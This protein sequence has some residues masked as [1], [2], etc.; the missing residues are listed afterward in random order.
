MAW[1]NPVKNDLHLWLSVTHKDMIA[2]SVYD[3]KGRL[4]QEQRFQ[5]DK[6]NQTK[7]LFL[8]TLKSGI[9]VISLRGT[10]IT[11]QFKIVKL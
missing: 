9:Y 8:A 5:L 1:P 4:L 11:Q 2:L 7:T 3:L 6:G 10:H